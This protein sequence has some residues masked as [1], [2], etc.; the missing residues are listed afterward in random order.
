MIKEQLEKRFSKVLNIYEFG[1]SVY[2]YKESKDLDYI[3]VVDDNTEDK[4]Q[5]TLDNRDVTVYTKKGFTEQLRRHDISSLECMWL[6]EHFKELELYDF[7]FTLDRST[8]RES[9]SK[10]ASNSW[11]KAKKKFKVPESYDP[12]VGKKSLFH[13]LRI[14]DFAIQIAEKGMIEDYTVS[15]HYWDFIKSLDSWDA[16][17][18]TFKAE[19]N[20][21]KTKLRELCPK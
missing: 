8:L 1:A 21:K 14:L 12:Y 19:Y 11:V 13:S 9:C 18:R 16:L 15:N 10:K 6:P 4:M 20:K 2:K 5:M 7:S 17:N 3:V